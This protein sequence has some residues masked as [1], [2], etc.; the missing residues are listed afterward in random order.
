MAQRLTD[1]AQSL[2]HHPTQLEAFFFVLTHA[3]SFSTLFAYPAATN[4]GQVFVRTMYLMLSSAWSNTLG[5]KLSGIGIHGGTRVLRSASRTL[6]IWL[7][8]FLSG[9]G[10]MSSVLLLTRVDTIEMWSFPCP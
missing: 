9:E 7:R 10:L 8:Y 4:L 6:A 2:T 1:I 3:L 5:P